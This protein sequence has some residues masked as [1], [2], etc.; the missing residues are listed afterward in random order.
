MRGEREHLE[1]DTRQG[2]GTSWAV[3]WRVGRRASLAL[4]G[5]RSNLRAFD[6]GPPIL[7]IPSP[8]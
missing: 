8:S 4:W 5:S 1:H 3:G 7:S 6:Q 2:E